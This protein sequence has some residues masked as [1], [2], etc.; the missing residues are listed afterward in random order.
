MINS[1][2][3]K[4]KDSYDTFLV[5]LVL[6]INALRVLL[7]VAETNILLYMLYFVTI[8]VLLAKYNKE[9]PK[10]LSNNTS[11]K[12]IF[13]FILY[14]LSFS[15]ISLVWSTYD[16][17]PVTFLKF[18]T[19]L[20]LSFLC[21][22][23]PIARIY[24]L[25]NLFVSFNIL[26]GIYCVLFPSR[27]FDLYELGLNYLNVTL[28]LGLSF[29]I[30]LISFVKA[31]FENKFKSMILWVGL[32]A[33]FFFVLTGFLARGVMIFPPIIMFVLTLFMGKKHSVKTLLIVG[34]LAIVIFFVSQLF[35]DM[36]SDYGAARMMRL[37][38]ETEDEDRVELW[39]ICYRIMMDNMWYV[40]GGGIEAFRSSYFYPHN[41][42]MH[43]LGEFGIVPLSIFVYMLYA[44]FKNFI[45]SQ[46]KFNTNERDALFFVIAGILYYL[47][48]FSK[49]F[50]MYDALPLYMMMALAFPFSQRSKTS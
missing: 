15:A 29:C 20:F 50:S 23:F 7:G 33:F 6:N 19:A 44:I 11:V 5:T 36:V 34:V 18:L 35:M 40:F 27:I 21:L 12:R 37:F 48:T 43:I 45:S 14:I 41:I 24:I 46:L 9:I 49:S 22:Y 13:F 28:T 16:N 31:Y 10:M 39:D 47:M 17:A 1:T 4:L 25:K 38:E 42:F 26:Y 32:S 2:S 3:I 8:A 30:T